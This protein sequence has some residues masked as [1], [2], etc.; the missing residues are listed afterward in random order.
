[1]TSLDR[2]PELGSEDFI[3][4]DRALAVNL[5]LIKATFLSNLL[6]RGNVYADDDGWF[7]LSRGKVES[8]TTLKEWRQKKII[9]ELQELKLFECKIVPQKIA[10]GVGG[11]RRYFK[12]NQMEIKRIMALSKPFEDRIGRKLRMHSGIHSGLI[13]T[14]FR[15]DRDGRIGITG[16]TVNIGAKLKAG[17]GADEVWASPETQY[18]IDPFFE[19]KA[20]AA[21]DMKGKGEPMVPYRILR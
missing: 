1:M 5:G 13:V 18:L 8:D 3:L 12:I 15:D 17:A 9:T 10:G 11:N 2:Y 14:N 4:I 16:D 7:H 6:F 21:V 19:T 20:L